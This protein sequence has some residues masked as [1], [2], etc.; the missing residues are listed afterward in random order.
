MGIS[1]LFHKVRVGISK[2]RTRH[3]EREEARAY[4]SRI[5]YEKLKDIRKEQER[6]KERIALYREPIIKSRK[7]GLQKVIKGFGTGVRGF[8]SAVGSIQK[9]LRDITPQGMR[10]S[11]RE[12][13]GLGISMNYPKQ[14]KGKGLLGL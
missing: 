3:F 5:K 11:K 2:A 14:R 7:E 8:G 9:G 13:S 6:H 12:S 4:E 1:D 10:P